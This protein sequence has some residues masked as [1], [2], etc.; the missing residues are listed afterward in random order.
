MTISNTITAE[1][2]FS[3]NDMNADSTILPR[4][5][6]SHNDDDKVIS[7]HIDI[8]HLVGT[9]RHL[10]LSSINDHIPVR[11]LN[12]TGTPIAYSFPLSSEL[13]EFF[14]SSSYDNSLKILSSH[15][16]QSYHMVKGP[17]FTRVWSSTQAQAINQLEEAIKQGK[18]LMIRLQD[19]EGFINYHPVDLCMIAYENGQKHIDTIRTRYSTYPM[20]LRD[21]AS[22]DNLRH[23]LQEQGFNK[24]SMFSL[25]SSNELNLYHCHYCC[26]P[27]GRYY[28]FYDIPRDN[29]KQYQGLDILAQVTS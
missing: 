12:E 24:E 2:T 13:N 17:R 14:V 9:E 7:E 26:Y 11:H 21:E 3:A 10:W 20:I 22:L 29:Y 23:A 28:N 16:F 1:S 18:A 25:P 15:R 8:S 19:E 4:I 6:Y 5:L 27:D